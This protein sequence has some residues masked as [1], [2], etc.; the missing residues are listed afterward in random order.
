[1]NMRVLPFAIDQ[2]ISRSYAHRKYTSVCFSIV[3]IV[4]LICGLGSL[5]RADSTTFY[6]TK[7]ETGG[8]V[9]PDSVLVTVDL[10]GTGAGSSTATITFTGENGYNLSELFFNVNG[11]YSF[12]TACGAGVCSEFPAGGGLDAYGMFSGEVQ[13]DSP[14]SSVT[15]NLDDGS[16]TSASNVLIPTTGASNSGDDAAATVTKSTSGIDTGNSASDI[17]GSYSPEPSSYL[18]FGSGLLALGAVFRKKLGRARA[19]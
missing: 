1:M 3:A 11:S 15:I 7:D 10:T 17:A 19:A 9:P 12:A 16:W 4:T 18:L 13:Y 8:T 5:A 14:Q 2:K 6:L